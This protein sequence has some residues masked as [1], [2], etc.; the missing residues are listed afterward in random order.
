LRLN[1]RPAKPD[2]PVHPGDRVQPYIP[3]EK[4]PKSRLQ[5]T[6]VQVDLEI[7]FEDDEIVVINKP[8]GIAVS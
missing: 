1:G 3:F 8:A 6:P 5:S 7:I 4:S 2:D